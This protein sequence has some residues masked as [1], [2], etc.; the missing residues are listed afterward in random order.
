MK[1]LSLKGRVS[2]WNGNLEFAAT[3]LAGD[4]YCRGLPE[5]PLVNDARDL[6]DFLASARIADAASGKCQAN[7][8]YIFL[9][10][11]SFA[12]AEHH[13]SCCPSRTPHVA[14]NV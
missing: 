6:A 4:E 8:N 13:S 2:R 3:E 11:T 1:H 5:N 10:F 7:Q 9:H 14:Q 12:R